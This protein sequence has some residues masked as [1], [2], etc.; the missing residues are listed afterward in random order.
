[1]RLLCKPLGRVWY[2]RCEIRMQTATARHRFRAG[3][4]WVFSR[5]IE[6]GRNGNE[7]IGQFPPVN[8]WEDQSGL[9]L[10][11]ELPGVDPTHLDVAVE[12]DSLTISGQRG[13]GSAEGS[14]ENHVRRERWFEP[15]Q[16]TVELPFDVNA[17]KCEAA[18]EKGVLT[19]KL[20]RAPEHQPK[21]LT[22]KGSD[23]TK[24]SEMATDSEKEK[25]TATSKPE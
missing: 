10:T 23:T 22:I 20:E 15:F 7:S 5:N 24:T 9:T 16:R 8:V 3:F 18:Y 11:A 17:D 13:T 12:K 6:R 19:I 1:M 21:K 14:E 2:A 4:D 25:G